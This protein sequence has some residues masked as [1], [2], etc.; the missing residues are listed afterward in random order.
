MLAGIVEV[1]PGRLLVCAL[2][3]SCE[4]AGAPHAKTVWCSVDPWASWYICLCICKTGFSVRYSAEPWHLFSFLL[5]FCRP[6][7]CLRTAQTARFLGKRISAIILLASVLREGAHYTR[8][9]YT[10]P[11]FSTIPGF[12]TI[13]IFYSWKALL[14]HWSSWTWS[15]SC[16]F[17]HWTWCGRMSAQPVY[18]D[19]RVLR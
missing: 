1:S 10:L 6:A 17:I 12:I 3:H 19:E 15:T 9:M 13:G 5:S 7:L 4:M 11:W 18:L 8:V 2:F 14:Y 16:P